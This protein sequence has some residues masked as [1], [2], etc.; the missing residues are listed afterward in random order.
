LSFDIRQDKLAQDPNVDSEYVDEYAKT[1]I[2]R[3]SIKEVKKRAEEDK[4]RR[5]SPTRNVKSAVA[6]NMRV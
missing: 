3:E 1:E 6:K 4:Q 2:I 5:E